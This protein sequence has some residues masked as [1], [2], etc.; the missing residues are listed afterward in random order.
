MC[1]VTLKTLAVSEDSR[2]KLMKGLS[3]WDFQGLSE[4]IT[5]IVSL[6]A[7]LLGIIMPNG[8][9]YR[10]LLSTINQRRLSK[11]G[12]GV[13]GSDSGSSTPSALLVYMKAILRNTE[14]EFTVTYKHDIRSACR[15]QITY[16]LVGLRQD[17]IGSQGATEALLLLEALLCE[18]APVSQPTSAQQAGNAKPGSSTP[19]KPVPQVTSQQLQYSAIAVFPSCNCNKRCPSESLSAQNGKGQ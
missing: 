19:A 15:V 7:S 10:K 8:R 17:T 14:K 6:S 9:R 16:I 11:A 5:S 13:A 3:D 18:P 12:P 4:V 1:A 2:T